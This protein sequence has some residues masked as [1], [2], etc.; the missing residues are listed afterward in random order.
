[1]AKEVTKWQSH[2]HQEQEEQPTSAYSKI[3][4]RS[5]LVLLLLHQQ[6]Y[7]KVMSSVR[8]SW[9]LTI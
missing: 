2:R 8:K 5:E 4:N 9:Q 3:Q 1:M 6:Q 7:K